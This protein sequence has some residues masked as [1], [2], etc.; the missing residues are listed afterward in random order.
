MER[1]TAAPRKT[2]DHY[3][4][5][6]TDSFSQEPNMAPAFL[7]LPSNRRIFM[8][9]PTVKR[10]NQNKKAGVVSAGKPI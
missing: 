1:T 7:Q 4:N 6:G 5:I 9:N 2:K 10:Q 3:L 8:K